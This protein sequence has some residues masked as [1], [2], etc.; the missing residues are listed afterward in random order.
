MNPI[1][2]ILQRIDNDIRQNFIPILMI[3]IYMVT[4]RFLFHQICPWLILT[5]RPCPACGLTRATRLL[6]ACRFADAWHMNP[7]VYLWIPF[8]LYLC[9]WRYLLGKK[10]P[11]ALPLMIMVCIAT[12][13][14]HLW[15]VL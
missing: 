15:R 2:K 6:F 3:L 5:H 8:L 11:F 9:F 7:T 4:A 1:H 10:P 14:V 12:I 13:A